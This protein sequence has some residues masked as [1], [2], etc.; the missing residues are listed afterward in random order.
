MN[1]LVHYIIKLDINIVGVTYRLILL[2]KCT[3][4]SLKGNNET[5][6]KLLIFIQQENVFFISTDE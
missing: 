2:I 4:F 6:I 5:A 1:K 3:L